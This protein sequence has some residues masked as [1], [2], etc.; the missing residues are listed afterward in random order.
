MPRTRSQPT[1][2]A[3]ACRRRAAR[4]ASTSRAPSDAAPRAS[5]LR[6]VDRAR[7]RRARRRRAGPGA[8]A[9]STS[10]WFSGEKPSVSPVCGAR[11]RVTSRRAPVVDRSPRP[12]RGP[13]GAGCTL[14]N[15][16]PGPRTTQSASIDRRDR[17]RA[18]RRVVR[19]RAGRRRPGPASWPPRPGRAPVRP[20]LGSAGSSPTTVGLDVERH[21]GHRQHPAPGAEQPGRPSRG[22]RPGRRAAPTGRRS[23][24]CR[25]RGRPASPSPANRCCS[26]SAPG[27]APLVVAAQRGQRHPQVTR[28]QHA[29]LGAQPAAGA[30][31]VGDRH[32]RGELGRSTQPQRG[33][34]RGQPVPAAER[35]THARIAVTAGRHSRPRSRWTVRDVDAAAS[36]SRRRELL[37]D[38]DAAVLAAGAADRDGQVALALALVARRGSA[39]A[40][41]A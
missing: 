21:G 34:R 15:H 26:R 40:A 32:H 2:R 20:S 23:A 39:R 18:G 31:V 30:A 38:R 13:A 33:Q 4:S 14:V 25:P 37:G 17:L 29:E 5:Q 35:D 1:G 9:A 28:R 11:L 27:A 22:R 12:G 16:E 3:A 36:R 41:R 24:G 10:R 7:G 19:D 8:C 6:I